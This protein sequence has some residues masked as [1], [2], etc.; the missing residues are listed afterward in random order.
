MRYIPRNMFI[1]HPPII[2]EVIL[3]PHIDGD[4]ISGVGQFHGSSFVYMT[5]KG[6]WGRRRCTYYCDDIGKSF[7]SCSSP[8]MV[9][10]TSRPVWYIAWW[11]WLQNGKIFRCLIL[12]CCDR[13]DLTFQR[14]LRRI[15]YL[16]ITSDFFLQSNS[17]SLHNTLITLY[18]IYLRTPT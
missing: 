5:K 11:V 3:K 6:L 10:S 14:G 7:M 8:L 9:H 13:V 4:I 1:L 2:N 18:S 15:W 16:P 17:F 12:L